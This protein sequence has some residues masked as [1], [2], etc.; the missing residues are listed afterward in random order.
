MI[1][2]RHLFTLGFVAILGFLGWRVYQRLQAPSQEERRGSGSREAPVEVAPVEHGPI[3]LRRTFAGSLEARAEFVV[4][5]K[6]GGRIEKLLYD[7][8]DVVEPEKVVALLDDD[9]YQQAKVQADADLAVAEATKSEAK[10][11]LEIAD[12]AL[13]RV[14]TLHG[15]GVAS[16]SQLDVA[17]ADRLAKEAGLKV[18]EAQVT[19]AEAAQKAAEIRL[20]YTQVAAR[21][22]GEGGRRVVS[23][24][25]V[26]E[27]DTVSANTPLLSIVQMDPLLAVIYVTER[28]FSRL[29]PGQTAKLVADAYPGEEFDGDISRIAPVF[30]AATRQA[31]VEVTVPNPDQLLKP[32]MFVR[33]TVVLERVADATVVPRRA[34]TTRANRTGVFLVS[35]DGTSVTWRPVREGIR[36]GERVQVIPDGSPLEG[37][38]VT[39]G[40][41]LV[42]DGSPIRISEASATD[43]GAGGDR[44]GT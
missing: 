40:Q 27:G 19:R 25:F 39:L 30:R 42:E 37:R 3:E 11:A 14:K 32:G 33:A 38:V 7:M 23:E 9:E 28:D 5:P 2:A 16:D 12:R 31:R 10:S 15:R 35:P 1:R 13:E 44:E 20:G 24:R 41:Q 43:P 22:T 4:A 34:L 21:W 18:A 6:I 8:G 26:D 29:R 36:S 17:S